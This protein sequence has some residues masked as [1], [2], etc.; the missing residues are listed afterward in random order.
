MRV[1]RKKREESTGY[2]T[3][4]YVCV[5]CFFLSFLLCFI[6][7]IFVLYSYTLTVCIIYARNVMCT[8]SKSCHDGWW[9]CECMCL[10]CVRIY[11]FIFYTFRVFF[12][13]WCIL[14]SRFDRGA[15]FNQN[16]LL[17]C[18]WTVQCLHIAVTSIMG[19]RMAIRSRKNRQYQNIN[20]WR[21]WIYTFCANSKIST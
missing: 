3:Y 11:I 20:V 5:D 17:I 21:F 15:Y 8:E 14:S 18:L 12:I 9:L 13:F 19:I 10:C 6:I 1:Q 16:D 7:I 2:N 4:P